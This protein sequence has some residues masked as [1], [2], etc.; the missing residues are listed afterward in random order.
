MISFYNL[1]VDYENYKKMWKLYGRNGYGVIIVFHFENSPTKWLNYHLSKVYYESFRNKNLSLNMQKGYH[2]YYDVEVAA[3]FKRKE[4]SFE[5]EVRLLFDSRGIVKREGEYPIIINS[6]GKTYH[7]IS[8]KKVYI[9]NFQKKMYEMPRLKIT[10]IIVGKKQFDF[11]KENIK[12]FDK[13][14]NITTQ[15]I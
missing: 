11:A 2:D 14:I 6:N 5:N 15:T 10:D 1:M 12:L 13:N 8:L 3:F 7:S 4:F 9:P